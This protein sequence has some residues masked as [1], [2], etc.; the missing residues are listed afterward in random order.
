LSELIEKSPAEILGKRAAEQFAGRLPF[1]FKVL[2][3]D[4]PLSLQAHPD[5][6]QAKEG[7]TREERLSIPLTAPNRNYKDKNHKPET[8]CALTPFWTLNGFRKL[9]DMVSL[10][11]AINSSELSHEIR[12]LEAHPDPDGLKSFFGSILTM[13]KPRQRRAVED[14]VGYAETRAG[15]DPAFEWIVKL[16]ACYPG[17]IGVLSPV[18]LNV[19]KLEP[20]QAMFLH[21]G[22]LH[23]YLEGAGIELMANSDNVLRG[24]LTSKHIDVQELLRVLDFTGGE[25]AILSPG[26]EAH[27]EHTYPSDADEFRLSVITVNTDISYTSQEDRSVE[28]MICTSGKA[29]VEDLD[30]N[31]GLEVETGTSIIVQA[32]V[33]QYAIEGEATL[34]KAS[35]P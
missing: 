5:S 23:T 17:D 22:Q 13:E 32:D 28:I 26:E 11:R 25:I 34:Y 19:V 10:L 21:T 12:D 7:F 30:R 18:L 2:A 14:A 33:R 4:S 6:D 20:G 8:L 31:K 16:D 3:A 27:G 24:G 35:V 1:L 9:S 15:N 29:S